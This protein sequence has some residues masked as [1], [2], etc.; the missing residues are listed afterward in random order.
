LPSCPPPLPWRAVASCP[1]LPA[2]D[3]AA[4]AA[5]LAGPQGARAWGAGAGELQAAALLLCLEHA[6]SGGLGLAG[7]LE[8]AARAPARFRQLLPAAQQLLLA[9][10]PQLLRC[11]PS[12]RLAAALQGLALL[13]P[14]V[15]QAGHG[16][17]AAAAWRGLRACAL[18]AA[19][20]D[21]LLAQGQAVRCCRRCRCHR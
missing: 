15:G 9:R 21:P 11:L 20:K 18:L 10:L 6:A 19:A 17:A 5:R 7:P 2:A 8:D 13:L 12:G 16:E 4:L 3:W 1:R 14:G